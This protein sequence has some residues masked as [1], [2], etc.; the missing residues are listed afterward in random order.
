MFGKS[1]CI[2]D[3]H[4]FFMFNDFVWLSPQTLM[5]VCKAMPPYLHF[6]SRR[7]ATGGGGVQAAAT[8]ALLRAIFTATR[9]TH[10][11]FTIYIK[12]PWKIY[13]KYIRPNADC[14]PRPHFFNV[15][16]EYTIRRSYGSPDLYVDYTLIISVAM[17]QLSQ[18][19]RSREFPF[20]WRPWMRCA[21]HV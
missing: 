15:I 16:S 17:I 11:F 2:H 12:T 21:R 8:A 18:L 13:A 9:R 7:R 10:R 14:R 19:F 6:H 1:T 4:L 5:P 20:R 3:F